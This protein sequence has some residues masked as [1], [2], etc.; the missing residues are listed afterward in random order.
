MSGRK[1]RLIMKRCEGEIQERQEALRKEWREAVALAKKDAEEGRFDEKGWE[2]G[3]GL[4]G[5]TVLP[6]PPA[7]PRESLK[8]FWAD[9]RE[10]PEEFGKL[11]PTQLLRREFWRREWVTRQPS[12][13]VSEGD[14]K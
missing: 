2:K 4:Y 10:D 9:S 3:G 5:R 13:S 7:P 12:Q 1:K 8:G 6:E 14:N 11:R